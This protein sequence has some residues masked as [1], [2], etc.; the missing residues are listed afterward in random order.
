M[1]LRTV[2]MG[3]LTF[4]NCM[5]PEQNRLGP[6]GAGL[7]VFTHAMEW[8]RGFILA[9]AIGAM[10]RLLEACRQY[11]RSR[12]QFG[13]AIGSFQQVAGRIVDMHLRLDAARLQ[14]YRFAWLKSQNRTALNEASVTKLCSSEAWVKS[15]EDALQIH[16]GYGY[17]TDTGIERELRDALASRIYSGTSEVQRVLLAQWLGLG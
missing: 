12:R 13:Q 14:Q 16:G 11:A 10:Q 9:G 5:V 8:E 15:C 6:E 2:P 17:L 7:A 4:D 3:E 1:G